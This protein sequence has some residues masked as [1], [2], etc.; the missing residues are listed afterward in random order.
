VAGL[1][2]DD[3]R[4][5]PRSLLWRFGQ[6]I[7]GDQG[8]AADSLGTFAQQFDRDVAAK[9]VADQRKAGGQDRG[10]VGGDMFHR[11]GL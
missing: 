8:D 2:G 5:F 6:G 4:F 9:A 7:G 10:G 3:H 1:G 11:V